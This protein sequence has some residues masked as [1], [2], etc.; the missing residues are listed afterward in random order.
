M[1]ESSVSFEQTRRKS[2]LKL[3]GIFCVA[4][5]PVMLAMLMY[6]GSVAIPTGKTNKGQLL[7][8]TLNLNSF[9]YQQNAEGFYPETGGKWLIVQTGSGECALECQDLAHIAR[10]VNI[11]M[12][13]EQERVARVLL[14]TQAEQ[15][16][17]LLAADYPQLSVKSVDESA[18][19]ELYKQADTSKTWNLWVSDPLGNVILRYDSTNSGYDL[20]DDLKKL[21]KLSNIG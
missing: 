15:T 9:G 5:V 14:S 1:S 13:R 11:L 10:Q 2:Q 16:Q 8:P 17:D 19:I 20:K 4:G 21:L 7:T 12:A 6:F 3:I 18:L